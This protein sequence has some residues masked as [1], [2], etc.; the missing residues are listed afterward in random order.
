[1][2]KVNFELN[3]DMQKIEISKLNIDELLEHMRGCITYF[4]LEDCYYHCC[5]NRSLKTKDPDDVRAILGLKDSKEISDIDD[6]RLEIKD[7][8]IRDTK[9]VIRLNPCPQ[10]ED[11]LCRI[12]DNPKRPAICKIYPVV[13]SRKFK[14]IIFSETCS[15]FLEGLFEPYY[16]EI[17]KRGYESKSVI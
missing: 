9:Y 12:Y 4:C 3:Q 15:A 14:T 7:F 16:Q 1:M 8:I 5:Q 6:Y 10:L 13:K 11:G 17:E 2:S